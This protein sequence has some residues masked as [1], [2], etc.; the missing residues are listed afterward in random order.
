MPCLRCVKY[1]R[2]HIVDPPSELTVTLGR[3]GLGGVR[4]ARGKVLVVREGGV[5]F[6]QRL[7]GDDP[8][9]AVDL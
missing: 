5:V 6:G 7:C 2:N 3:A 9:A 8:S 4:V 1:W